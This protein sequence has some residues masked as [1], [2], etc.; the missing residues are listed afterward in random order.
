[1]TETNTSAERQGAKTA[2][3]LV[4]SPFLAQYLLVQPGRA[5]GVRIPE[6]R[7]EELRAAGAEGR[8][9]PDWLADA[10]REAWGIELSSSSVSDVVLVRERSRYGYGKASWEINLG[11]DYDC[12]H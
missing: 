8:S 2:P 5:V 4:A 1:M 3:R 11:C 6:V 10:A 12:V 7:Y 9:V